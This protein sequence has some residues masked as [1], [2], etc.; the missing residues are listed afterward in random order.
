MSITVRRTVL[1]AIIAVLSAATVVAVVRFSPA[2]AD[3]AAD[4]GPTAGYNSTRI[5]NDTFN[6]TVASGFGAAEMGGVYTEVEDGTQAPA[7]DPVARTSVS[8]GSAHFAAVSPGHSVDEVL[9]NT[10]ALD[11]SGQLTF[12]VPKVGA[13]S[14]GDYSGLELRRQSNLNYYAARVRIGAGGAGSISV[15]HQRSAGGTS[16]YIIPDISIGHVS[17]GQKI[18]VQ[19]AVIGSG[20]VTV[21][22]RAWTYG[23]NAP[24]WT[25][26][27]DTTGFPITLAGATGVFAYT[28]GGTSPTDTTLAY[29]AVSSLTKIASSGP[30]STP[31]TRTTSATATPSKVAT[32]TTSA[33]TATPTPSNTTTASS[34]T[35]STTAPPTTSS[36]TTSSSPPPTPGSGAGSAPLGSTS[37]AI[38]AGAVFVSTSGSDGSGNGSVGSP[39]KTVH[40]ALSHIANGGTIVVRGGDYNQN[41]LIQPILNNITIESYPGETVWFDGSIPVTGWTQSGS[42]WVHSGWTYQFDSSASFTT[43][44]DAG[45]FVNASYPMAAHPDEV[46]MDGAQ[47]K[48]VAS[49]PAAGQFAVD[50]SAQTITIGSDPNGHALR[51]SDLSQAFVIGAGYVTLRGFGVE[52]Y[53]TPLPLMGAIYQ[54]GSVG[55]GT[56]EN[57][58]IENNATIGLSTTQPGN[59]ISHVTADYNGMSGMQVGTNTYGQD[60]AGETVTESELND[61]DTEGFV[62]GPATGALKVGRISGIAITNNVVENNFQSAGIW[63]DQ[64][65]KNFQITGNTVTGNGASYG[66]ETELS[67]IG[68]VANN[69]ITGSK[70]GYTAFDTGD[71]RVYNNT[72]TGNTVWQIGL[73]QDAR[74]QQSNTYGAP[75]LV[76]N[77]TTDNN[78]LGSGGGFQFY[79]MDKGTNRPASAMNIT[80]TGNEFTATPNSM[81]GWGTD[82][83][84]VT[85][86]NTPSALDA[87]VGTSWKNL[88]DSSGGFSPSAQNNASGV[89]EPLPADIAAMIGVPAG[90]AQIGAF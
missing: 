6:R 90:T 76:Q 14:F 4:P 52:N 5:V 70:Y 57:L 59:L 66:I 61:N 26:T 43:G 67:D 29:F 85:I 47:L 41:T 42:T 17:A 87:G 30:S 69:V 13:T 22:A 19:L 65:T 73:S 74:Y 64:S 62:G 44:S 2:G 27:T 33:S 68:V 60:G 79:A 48:Q 89:A 25:T 71:V 12:T 28:S 10:A 63:T 23:S 54:G 7:A 16:P 21:S 83:Q 45:G 35:S 31:T 82:Q 86:Y 40:V 49:N 55:H 50:Y 80:L 77:V 18:V 3:G 53:A 72:I 58:V 8:P 51:A 39:Y 20:P 46:F 15:I 56:F 84:T 34:T 78:V 1:P 37:Y 75:W 9:N 32:P 38:P 81:V 36:S 88:Q 24:N 11:E